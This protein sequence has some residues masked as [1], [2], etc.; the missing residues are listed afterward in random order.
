MND[1]D[2]AARGHSDGVKPRGQSIKQIDDG[3]SPV[4]RSGAVGQPGGGAIGIDGLDFRE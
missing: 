3:R 4:G 2:D 1:R